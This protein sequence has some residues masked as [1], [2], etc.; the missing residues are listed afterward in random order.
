[1]FLKANVTSKLILQIKSC[2]NMLPMN[3]HGSADP[4]IKVY[5]D[6]P[7]TN[8]KGKKDKGD[9]TETRKNTRNPIFNAQF[10]YDIPTELDMEFTYLHIDAYSSSESDG[11]LMGR[12]A[13]QLNE[14]W[15]EGAVTTGWFKWLDEKRGQLL[16]VQDAPAKQ[17]APPARQPQQPQQSQQQSHASSGSGSAID[18]P[19]NNTA[20]VASGR[21]GQPR[22]RSATHKLYITTAQHI[23]LRCVLP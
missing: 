13:F 8:K 17:P 11:N 21:G 18:T 5:L 12:M 15:Q 10:T 16:N 23:D 7:L 3:S 22:A 9:K 4:F 1:M 6:P 2:R 20:S 14:I 19:P